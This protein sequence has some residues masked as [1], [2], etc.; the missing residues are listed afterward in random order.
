[1]LSAGLHA[2]WNFISKK[3]NPSAA[4][5]MMASMTGSVIWLIFF[6]LSG[7][8]FKNL[9]NSFYVMLLGSVCF[10]TIYCGSLAYAYRK[11]DISLAYPLGRA[12]PV[13]MVAAVSMLFHLGH[14]LSYIQISGMVVIFGGC[15]LMPLK[16]IT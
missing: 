13:V 10:E 1:M 14:P 3:H 5:Y 11:C 9:P 4:F 8:D 7:I 12:L 16:K 6:I 2:T 15:L